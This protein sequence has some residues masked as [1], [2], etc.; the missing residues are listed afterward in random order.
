MSAGLVSFGLPRTGVVCPVVLP[1]VLPTL[2]GIMPTSLLA[3][4]QILR[5]VV[6][7]V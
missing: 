4:M 1:D 7:F 6:W 2:S 3:A 5:A